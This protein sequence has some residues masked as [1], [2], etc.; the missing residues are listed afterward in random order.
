MPPEL[1]VSVSPNVLWP[2]NHKYVAVQATFTATDDSDPDPTVR[3]LTVTS[4]E[5]DNGLGDGDMSDD[6]VIV[7]NDSI[8]LRAEGA[9]TGTG[10]V[11]TITY[12]AIDASGNSTTQSATVT[13]PRFR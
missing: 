8:L 12:A 3:L 6:V 7:G 5:R 4:N 11:Y 9:G 2:P 13:V 10:R 1:A